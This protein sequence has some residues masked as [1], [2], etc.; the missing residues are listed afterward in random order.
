MVVDNDKQGS[1]FQKE[2]GPA[3][4]WTDPKERKKREKRIKI[5]EKKQE[6]ENQNKRK[7]KRKKEKTAVK[8]RAFYALRPWCVGDLVLAREKGAKKRVRIFE[9]RWVGFFNWLVG[10]DGPT[11]LDHGAP[12]F[13]AVNISWGFFGFLAFPCQ[14]DLMRP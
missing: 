10:R 12:C 11:Y 5:Q 1:C 14:F 4:N 6:K 9:S 3:T 8:R 13:V 7:E 2:T